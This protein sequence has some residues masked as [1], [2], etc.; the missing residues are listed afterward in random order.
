MIITGGENVY[1]S[2]VENILNKHPEIMDSV[3][4]GIPVAQWGESVVAAIIL[5][6][7]RLT[8]LDNI[9]TFVQ[10]YLAGYKTPKRYYIL[11]EFPKTPIGKIDKKAL[12]KMAKDEEAKH[13]SREKVQQ[14]I[15]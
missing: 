1:P 11:K 7:D 13:A 3:V 10:D 2:E 4:F 14:I 5:K 6:D 9:K 12:L 15:M 8:S